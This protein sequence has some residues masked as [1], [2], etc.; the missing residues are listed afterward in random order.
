MTKDQF[1]NREVTT[2]GEDYIFDLLDRGYEAIELID[3]T[4]QTRWSWRL[5]N[6]SKPATMIHGGY[7]SVSPV[8]D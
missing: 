7:R 5:T 8:S 3:Q 6:A 2:W 4:G 1:I